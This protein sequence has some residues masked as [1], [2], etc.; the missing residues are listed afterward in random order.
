MGRLEGASAELNR[1]FE[2]ELELAL[3][4]SYGD[5]VAGLFRH[6]RR[7]YDC[8]IA[9]REA[10]APDA[11][12]RFVAAEGRI[13]VASDDIRKVGGRV[14]KAADE[15]MEELKTQ[16]RF[17]LWLLADE[18]ANAVLNP[19]CR[20]SNAL[21][22]GMTDY[23]RTVYRLMRDGLS[24]AQIAERLGKYPQSVSDAAKRGGAELVIE[25]ES[26]ARR[27]LADGGAGH[28]GQG[29]DA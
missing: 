25:A 9:L 23:Q 1:R 14:F 11:A 16:R 27:V 8:V 7:V 19:L 24:G 20:L 15:G 2:D 12:L 26:A 18:S 13:G 17:A 10:I 29:D 3:N 28:G 4:L 5:E 22:E 21:V 6:P